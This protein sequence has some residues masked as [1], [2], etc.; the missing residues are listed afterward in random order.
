MI[1]ANALKVGD[2][3]HHGSLSGVISNAV[4]GGL[5]VRVAWDGTNGEDRLSRASPLWR[6][7]DAQAADA[8]GSKVF[9][10]C[11]AAIL[12]G[13][14]PGGQVQRMLDGNPEFRAW[15]LR[16]MERRRF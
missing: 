4:R 12:S 14:V 1:D 10:A 7:M 13:Q 11:E 3:V 16:R 9:E 15:Y 2:R 6:F 5:Y 8:S